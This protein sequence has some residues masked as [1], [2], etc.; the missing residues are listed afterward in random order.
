[1][2]R[3]CE[4]DEAAEG[5]E[6]REHGHSEQ[7]CVWQRLWP[8]TARRT[9]PHLMHDADDQENE[10]VTDHLQHSAADGVAVVHEHGAHAILQL[11]SDLGTM[12]THT[13]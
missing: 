7:Q 13:L 2:A 10:Q 1:M 5:T 3:A 6:G 12:H 9:A 11:A 8:H 4:E